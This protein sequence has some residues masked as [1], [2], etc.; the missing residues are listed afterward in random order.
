M[1][2]KKYRTTFLLIASLFFCS[3][4]KSAYPPIQGFVTTGSYFY[5]TQNTSP[6]KAWAK[7]ADKVA[8]SISRVILP[9]SM[10]TTKTMYIAPGKN[11]LFEKNYRELLATSMV[12][13]NFIISNRANANFLLVF[14]SYIVPDLKE[15]I[16]NTSL[17]NKGHIIF[18]DSSVFNLT[19]N[20]SSV[21][22]YKLKIS[23][24]KNIPVERDYKIYKLV[25]K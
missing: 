2:L 10:A 13:E 20:L 11:T 16:V 23:Q 4:V 7:L 5:I 12:K 8:K 18:R 9:Y 3:C 21:N 17:Y 6:S 22:D 19:N 24:F 14:N 1:N 25:D 15:V